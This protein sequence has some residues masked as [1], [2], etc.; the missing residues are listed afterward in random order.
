[1]KITKRELKNL[2]K[3]VISE[4]NI[5]LSDLENELEG[6]T[7][8]EIEEDILKI[9]KRLVALEKK[10]KEMSDQYQAGAEEF[11]KITGRANQTRPEEQ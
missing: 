6:K 5:N 1:M 2:I 4:Q 7:D 8:Q 11:S 9:A 3:E 10:M